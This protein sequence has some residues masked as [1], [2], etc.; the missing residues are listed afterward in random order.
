MPSSSHKLVL[1]LVAKVTSIA[2]VISITV[3]PAIAKAILK[4]LYL[5]QVA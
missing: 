5:S 4:N 2:R 1:S 3:E